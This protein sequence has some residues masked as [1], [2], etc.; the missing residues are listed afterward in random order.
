MHIHELEELE[1]RM[2]PKLWDAGEGVCC[3]AY[4]LGGDCCHA[5]D[6]EGDQEEPMTREELVEL[7]G[8]DF[9]AET[10]RMLAAGAARQAAMVPE[11]EEP[12]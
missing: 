4:Q 2:G 5:P 9:V 3:A 7:H 8:E 12:F 1:Y 10:E 6:Y 11:G